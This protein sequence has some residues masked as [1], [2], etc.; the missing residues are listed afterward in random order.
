LKQNLIRISI[1]NLL[2][3]LLCSGASFAQSFD[4]KKAVSEAEKLICGNDELKRLDEELAK[5]Y[6]E[7]LS[8]PNKNKT[9]IRYWQRSWLEERDSYAKYKN[10]YD[11]ADVA[12][13]YKSRIIELSFWLRETSQNAAPINTKSKWGKDE[14]LLLTKMYET[15][16]K[17]G[18]DQFYRYGADRESCTELLMEFMKLNFEPVAPVMKTNDPNDTDF[19]NSMGSCGGVDLSILYVEHN[20]GCF[21]FSLYTLYKGNFDGSE[22]NG[23][24][25]FLIAENPR[26]ENI[27][28]TSIGLCGIHPNTANSV[29]A[30]L[31]LNP[32]DNCSREA[33]RDW[34]AYFKKYWAGQGSANMQGSVHALW[35][36]KL[37]GETLHYDVAKY[38]GRDYAYELHTKGNQYDL[39]LMD[40]GRYVCAGL[41]NVVDLKRGY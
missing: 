13:I 7:I 19:K 30:A 31:L 41:V 15:Y 9:R 27:L 39:G 35:Y 11:E 17:Y 22:R 5:L 2:I 38:K 18:F 25:L 3:L 12:D 33:N 1:V 28:H 29:A 4:C 10:F 20:I 6:K 21:T 37:P 14:N 34:R 40:T 36:T 23:D 24:E 8:D 26:T 32:Y 16:K